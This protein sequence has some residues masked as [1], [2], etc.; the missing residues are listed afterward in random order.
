[1]NKTAASTATG[2]G[3]AKEKFSIALS[4]QMLLRGRAVLLEG[5]L[6]SRDDAFCMLAPPF[7]DGFGAAGRFIEIWSKQP[8]ARSYDARQA[9][10]HVSVDDDD[11]GRLR[12]VLARDLVI[13]PETSRTCIEEAVV[14]LDMALTWTGSVRA[15]SRLS[16]LAA[17]H[18]RDHGDPAE[19]L[20]AAASAVALAAAGAGAYGFP[21]FGL[22][23]PRADQSGADSVERIVAST[24]MIIRGLAGQ[25]MKFAAAVAA[26]PSADRTTAMSGEVMA[27]L[28]SAPDR[29]PF[30]DTGSGD[31]A[32]FAGLL[33]PAPAFAPSAEDLRHDYRSWA[34]DMMANDAP[35][36][37]VVDGLMMLIGRMTAGEGFSVRGLTQ[38]LFDVQS[39]D[40][41]EGPEDPTAA[42]IAEIVDLVRLRLNL[43]TAHLGDPE[44]ALKI[45]SWSAGNAL[46]NLHRP[47]SWAV[48]VAALAWA[49]R[50]AIGHA[51]APSSRPILG[52]PDVD[53]VICE[54]FASR[55]CRT[56][57][58]LA[59]ALSTV[60]V[61]RSGDADREGSSFSELWRRSR[62][63]DDEARRSAVARWSTTGASAVEADSVVVVRSIA[64]ERPHAKE[65]PHAEFLPMVGKPIP[66]V[67]T[68]DVRAVYQ[69]LTSE[70]PHARN[71][72]DVILRD[73]AASRTASWRPTILVGNPGSGKTLLTVSICDAMQIPCRVFSCGGVADSSFSG[74]SRQWVTGR[75]S[76]PLQTIR[77]FGK[78][79]VAII[80]DELDKV[81]AAGG[82]NGSLIDGLLSMTEKVSS[83]RLFDVYLEGEVDLHRVLWLATANDVR[84]LHPAL[85]DR[86]RILHMP[87][88]RARDIHIL[89]PRVAAD[90]A[91]R[92]GLTPEWVAPFDAVEM[93]IIA[94][95]WPGGSLRRLS[96]IVETL[97]D[98]R[99]HPGRAN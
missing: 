93:D 94:D 59:S 24:K 91:E 27:M 85:L 28:R 36:V 8:L 41:P 72:I 90:I 82:S 16:S 22:F 79:N 60:S 3:A 39:L 84:L 75:A 58:G 92:R 71:V 30:V 29:L 87:D 88:A 53:E 81:G 95:L 86:F 97:M 83:C 15:A 49:E 52:L 54:R 62:A 9:L 44:A 56:A 73:T 69:K 25:R 42:R 61:V 98:A 63:V 51:V 70:A 40:L 20:V 33:C 66:L 12:H 89:L 99:D 11:L 17:C 2:T 68:A 65:G 43:Y 23:P 77:K 35:A 18:S 37:A 14:Q 10:D 38:M 19:R 78:A 64:A 57:S 80:L 5:A 74:T 67:F 34:M 32:T 1:V 48:L 46:A 76:V 21:A 26:I 55:L 50:S 7:G 47:G 31:A 4:E 6:P 45:A 13:A 96:R